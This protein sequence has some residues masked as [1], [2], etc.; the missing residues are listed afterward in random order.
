MLEEEAFSLAP[1]E[2]SGILNVGDKFVM[3]HCL[4]RTKPIVQD[5][6]AVKNELYK[7][8]HEKK[9]RIAMADEF[10]R[11]KEVAQ[12]NNFIAGTSQRGR[13]ISASRSG[14]RSVSPADFQVP[15]T[16]KKR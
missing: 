12:I 7:D 1:G 5:F 15:T 11:L 2:L 10:D 9:L 14:G 4:G 3:L 16:A 8:I 13:S 6:N